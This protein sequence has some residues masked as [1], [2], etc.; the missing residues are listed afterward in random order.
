MISDSTYEARGVS[1]SKKEVHAAVRDLDK[2]LFPGAF[3]MVHPDLLG[4]SE[5]HAVALHAD[6]AG[7]KGIIAYLYWKETGDAS[8]FRGLAQDAAVMNT[9]DLLCIGAVDEF[10]LSNTIGRNAH[11]IPG[12]ILKEIITGY[13]ELADM[14]SHYGVSLTLAGG[15]TADVGDVVS[16]L[17]VDATVAVRME[18]SRIIDCTRI[19]PG[20]AIV[21]IASF[22]RCKYETTENSGI[23]SNGLTAARHEL[24]C[25]DY[26]EKYPESFSNTIP[27]NQVYTGPYH[28]TDPLPGSDLDVGSAILS[29]TRTYLPF[30]KTLFGEQPDTVC[31][32]VHCTGGGQV[33]CRNFGG[34]G[35]RYIKDNLFPPPPIFEAIQKQAHM[36]IRE[37]Y[38]VFN[39][40]H[41]LEIFCAEDAVEAIVET[42]RLFHLNARQIGHVEAAATPTS[43]EVQITTQENVL[44][45]L[46]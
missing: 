10:V 36:Q 18:R 11:R 21:G 4:N 40:G 7:T 27:Q 24:L 1:A 17:M 16:T 41:R 43:N 6:G 23:G 5:R 35:L 39:M 31:G 44:E 13:E 45:Y 32:I 25:S 3:C 33:K 8:V 28:L 20:N 38:Q 37:M 26:A 29:P 34:P 14:L 9:D 46:S 12:E 30:I 15:E 2:G 42:A 22:G 19:A